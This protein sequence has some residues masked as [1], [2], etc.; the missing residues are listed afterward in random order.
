MEKPLE[1]FEEIRHQLKMSQKTFC[2]HLELHPSNYSAMKAGDKP[3]FLKMHIKA[4]Q[5]WNVNCVWLM[6]G[7]G[8][9]FINNQTKIQEI[10]MTDLEE[11]Q[12]KIKS[13]KSDLEKIQSMHDTAGSLENAV[14]KYEL[15]KAT[16]KAFDE[17]TEYQSS[18]ELYID[19]IINSN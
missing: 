11:I 2:E 16:K 6:D 1:R 14:H 5:L 10:K 7:T 9:K 12:I 3:P 13:I 18:L 19:D 17:M 8:Q 15:T 4:Q